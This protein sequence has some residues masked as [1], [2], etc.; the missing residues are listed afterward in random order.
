[1]AQT[2]AMVPAAVP[3]ADRFVPLEV[4]VNGAKGGIWPFLERQ[5]VL[6]A[7]ID[8]LEEWRI[9]PLPDMPRVTARGGEYVAL[10]ALPGF[11]AKTDFQNQSIALTLAPQAFAATKLST[12]LSERVKRS[13]VLPSAFFNYDVSF[14][15][16]R[17]RLGGGGRD[18]GAVTEA[19]LSNDWGVLTSSH[20]GR[21]L[22]GSGGLDASSGWLRLE[23]TFTRDDTERNRTLRLGDTATRQGM[24]GRSVYFGG[25]QYGSNFALTPGFITQPLPVLRGVSSAP[26]TVELYVNDVLKQTSNVPPG[27]F[28]IDNTASVTGNGEAR[29]VV[30]DLLGRE[31]VIVQPF[32]TSAEL[33]TKGLN[34][35]SVEAG[36]LRHDLGLA[37][38]NYGSAFGSGTWRHGW[39]DWLTLEGRG[40]V[41]AKSWTGGLGLIT[42]LPGGV[43]GRAAYVTSEDDARARG[44]QWVLGLQR[45]WL[46]ALAQVQL[47]GASRSFRMLGMDRLELPV[48]FQ[49]AASLSY[50]TPGYGTVGLGFATIERF[51]ARR[52]TTV[53]ANYSQL[54]GRRNNLSVSVSKVLDGASGLGVNA[55]LFVPLD[56]TTIV[57]ATANIR[58]SSHDY[59]ASASRSPDAQ[60]GLGWRLQG[61]A[62]QDQP[63][64]EG[65]LYYTGRYGRLYG[66]VSV[67]PDQQAVRTSASGALVAADAHLFAT[68]RIEQ[69][70][71][72]AQIKDM[73]NIGV[74]LGGN[75]MTRTDKNGIAILP[76]LSPYQPN[77]VRINPKDLPVSAEIGNIES[78]IVPSWRSGVKVDFPVRS[79]RA[80]LLRI[81]LDD[82]D[83]APAGATV[84]LSGDAE[85]FYVARRG[86]AYVTGMQA[87]N[88]LAL[89]WKNQQCSM[90][91]VLPKAANDEIARVGPLLCKGVNR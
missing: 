67:S 48:K 30:R 2:P 88:K 21:N 91:V 81:V 46:R 90:D 3:V 70:F 59:Y 38:A 50:S 89:T 77:S 27:P 49:A 39:N 11:S 84:K 63:Y 76:V 62:R 75:V 35:W 73:E 19:G 78:I 53:S 56:D 82:G 12:E 33:L 14:T 8:A 54:V 43:L 17:S 58:G 34:D 25:V 6:H 61:G 87:S 29:L 60:E 86:E 41:S 64:S 37:N 13:P 18:F 69:S 74:G 51:L 47:E 57:S 52:I 42:T 4:T 79:G 36:T 83:V 72:I 1:M 32:F 28:S 23:T 26:S 55:S 45:E 44:H 20:V 71:A 7:P 10:P 5:G 85:Y 40:E 15:S 65:G 31:V 9:Q 66:D 22:T 68:R 16:V 80:A 24:W